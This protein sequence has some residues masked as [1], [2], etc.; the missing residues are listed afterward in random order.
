M[1]GLGAKL[2]KTKD[3]MNILHTGDYGEIKKESKA[4]DEVGGRF[5]E[6]RRTGQRGTEES[7]GAS[8]NDGR[9][10]LSRR[11]QKVVP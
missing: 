10:R 8:W 7:C 2:W 6:T 3:G 1:N 4:L 5:E 9:I 11:R